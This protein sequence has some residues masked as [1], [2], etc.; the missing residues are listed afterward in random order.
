MT[1]HDDIVA[2]LLDVPDLSLEVRLL[3]R[4]ADPVI[5]NSSDHEVFLFVPDLHVLTPERQKRFANYAFNH[6][7][8]RVLARLLQRLAT[9]RADWDD[10]GEHKLVTVQLG[11]FFDLWR[12]FPHG[13]DPGSVPD[14]AHG[15]LRDVL[16]RGVDRHLPCLKAT[17][18]LGNHD[19]KRGT[20]LPEI[21]F[22]LKA[23]NRTEH[24]NPFLFTTHGDAFDLLEI[25]VPDAIEEFIVQF[26][27]SLTP[28]NKY[29]VADWGAAAAK[30]NKPIKDLEDCIMQ[31]R[32][33]L[34]TASGAVRVQPG[35]AL[36]ARFARIVTAPEDAN[37]GQFEKYHQSITAAT[38]RGLDAGSVRVVVVGH[39]HAAA[40]ILCQPPAGRPLLMMDVGAWIEQ[41]TYPLD[42]GGT[43]TEPSA[44]LGVIHGNDARL[45]QIRV[46]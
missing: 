5:G 8:T 34:A 13:A 44:Q 25:L 16:Y 40:M 36:P 9:L 26:V 21:P 10:N 7:G 18:L 11:D 3:G 43:V 28:V 24:G 31:P 1:V 45:Y 20:P 22:R 27:G 17:M 14:D 15:D 42:E 30:T 41:C 38:A 46:A 35:D 12:E 2:A 29:P 32:H 6:A 37:H 33:D 23:F 39:S 19:T 4:I